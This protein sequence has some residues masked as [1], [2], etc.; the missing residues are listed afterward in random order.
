MDA[1]DLFERLTGL[2]EIDVAAQQAAQQKQLVVAKERA[3]K[4]EVAGLLV[5]IE[6]V[7]PHGHEFQTTEGTYEARLCLKKAGFSVARWKQRGCGYPSDPWD[8]CDCRLCRTGGDGP[9][10]WTITWPLVDKAAVK[11][12]TEPSMAK[13]V[14][15]SQSSTKSADSE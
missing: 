14:H 15:D 12:A 8:I 13:P 4:L 5:D 9:R 6:K 10:M 3:T 1:H 11:A 2:T 7:A